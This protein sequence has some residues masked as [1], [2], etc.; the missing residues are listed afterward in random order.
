MDKLIC[1]SL[2]HTHYWYY[3]VGYTHDITIPIILYYTT[4]LML[5]RST[6]YSVCWTGE[7][8][9]VK[10]NRNQVKRN[11][12]MTNLLYSAILSPYQVYII[13]LNSDYFT[14]VYNT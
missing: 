10:H 5:I 8:I 13:H 3:E 14:V 7:S 12:P 11:F 1:A 2:S 4:R 9:Q 6:R